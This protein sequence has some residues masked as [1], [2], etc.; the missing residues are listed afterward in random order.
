MENSRK[1]KLWTGPMGYAEATVVAAGLWGIGAVLQ[2]MNGPLPEIAMQWPSN[3]ICGSALFFGIVVLYLLN[4]KKAWVKWI[5]GVPA[6]IVS[7]VFFG[8]LSTIMALTPQQPHLD[9]HWIMTLGWNQMT[10]SY[11]FILSYIFLLVTLGFATM[12]RCFPWRNKNWG[13]F[14]NHAGLWIA[15]WAAGFGAYD[16]QRLSMD[17]YTGQAEWRAYDAQ[18]RVHELDMALEL[19]QFIMEEY[20]PKLM[21]VNPTDGAIY[22][23]DPQFFM[24][25]ESDS[26]SGDIMGYKIQTSRMMKSAAYVA[27]AGKARYE[28][29]NEYGASPT[30][31]VTVT[32]PNGEQKEGWISAGSFAASPAWLALDSTHTLAMAPP[33]PKRFASRVK[34]FKKGEQEAVED[35]VEV[36]HPI[37]V[38]DWKIYQ[39]SY[40]D[41][42]GRWSNLSVVELVRDP[43]LWVVYIGVFM[44]IVGALYLFTLNKDDVSPVA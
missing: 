25:V 5:S 19:Q 34:V 26:T 3:I 38:G 18:D 31:Y 39:L 4:R 35:L 2:W 41:S 17:L 28:E 42:K 13:F 12:K 24:M 11:P 36:N 21:M 37:S 40:D 10:G 44:M 8:L 22:D 27:S 30:A 33:E 23:Q 29:V 15:L 7:L 9:P 6:A 43:W 16:V 32:L 1:R 20:A 14:A